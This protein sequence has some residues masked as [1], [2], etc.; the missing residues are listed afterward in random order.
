MRT[1]DEPARHWADH[2][3]RVV[4]AIGAGDVFTK[5]RD[6]AAWLGRSHRGPHHPRQDIQAGQS[7]PAVMFVQVA[8]DQ[9][10][11]DLLLQHLLTLD[12]GRWTRVG[13]HGNQ[14]PKPLTRPTMTKMISVF[15]VRTKTLWPRHHNASAKSTRGYTRQDF[16]RAWAAYCDDEGNTPT[17]LS[18]IKHL[19]RP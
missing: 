17:H 13:E 8:E 14:A 6:F 2:L 1:S 19:R 15:G 16:E 11:T 5:G 4:A 18:I 3:Q 7:L 10:P 12:D 9:I